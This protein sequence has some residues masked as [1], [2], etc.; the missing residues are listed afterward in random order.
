MWTL[1]SGAK[2]CSLQCQL[3]RLPLSLEVMLRVGSK[4]CRRRS[5]TG[6]EEMSH[7]FIHTTKPSGHTNELHSPAV[8]W[9]QGLRTRGL[10]KVAAAALP[11]LCPTTAITQ[12]ASP[13][14]TQ[15]SANGGKRQRGHKQTH[16]DT[17]AHTQFQVV[18]ACRC[19]L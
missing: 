16:M 19:L 12:C 2:V 3:L 1:F 13:S 6:G 17:H 8:Q 10:V 11:V 18:I 7:L 14:V 15:S 4:K 5:S 9:T